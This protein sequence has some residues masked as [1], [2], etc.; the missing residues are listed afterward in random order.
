MKHSYKLFLLFLAIAFFG[1]FLFSQKRYLPNI[2]TTSF[3]SNK[4]AILKS[5]DFK[6]I[7]SGSYKKPCFENPTK[8]NEDLG[9]I[10]ENIGYQNNKF[11]L[12]IYAETDLVE[13]AGDMVNSNGGDWGYVLIP[14]NVKDYEYDKWKNLFDLINKKH[15]IPIVQLWNLTKRDQEEQISQSAYFLNSLPWPI[16][17]RYISVYNEVNDSRF[18]RG[19]ANPVSYAEI[20]SDTI[21]SFKKV[22]ADFFMLNGAFNASA[23]SGEGYIDEEAFLIQMNKAVPGIFNKL[24]GWASHPYPMP[25]FRGSP[26]NTGRD[27]IK[28]YEWELGLL[29]R[30]FGINS[31]PVFITETGWAHKEGIDEEIKYLSNNTIA[32]YY[33]IAFR[34]AWLPDKRV[35]AITPFTIKYPHPNDH[36]SF[37]D[38]K[39]KPYPQFKTLQQMQ[40]VAGKPPFVISRDNKCQNL[41]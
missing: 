7:P 33:K 17:N 28:A 18:W 12:Y 26:Y 14:I 9:N 23:R 3:L 10:Q 19:E 38:S 35:V 6:N 25:E 1:T 15:L 39:E 32:E 16:K 24:N 8:Y 2:I 20:L 5:L 13:Y 37:L 31:I 11:G 29:S 4:P 22:N 40:K 27:S 30:Y 34:D 36:F 21:D 41:E